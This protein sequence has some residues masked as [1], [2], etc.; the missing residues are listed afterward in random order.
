V[1]GLLDFLALAFLGLLAACVI[2]LVR[3]YRTGSVLVRTQVRWLALAGL[4]V[5]GTLLACWVCAV[6]FHR[7]ELA[8][9]GLVAMAVAIPA[10]TAI[11]ILRTD[12]YDVDRALVSGAA[13]GLLAALVVGVVAAV[14]AVAGLV[15]GQGSTIIAVAATA[16]TLLALN[17]MRRRLEHLLSR[18]L[19][20]ARERALQAV[21]ALERRVSAGQAKPEDLEDVLR[22][23]LRDPGLRLG[24][25]SPGADDLVDGDGRLIEPNDHALAIQIAGQ[26][27]GVLVPGSNSWRPPPREVATAVTMLVEMV[28]LR[29]ELASALVDVEASRT[30]LLRAGYD[31]R[32]RLE[33]D[34]HDGAQQRLVALGMSLRLAQRHLPSGTVDVDGVIDE[35]VAEIGTAVAELRKIAHGL[36]PSNL[37]DG[38]PAALANLTSKSPMPIDLD[39][40]A[41][42]LPDAVCT[43]AYFVAS[44][45][46]TNA[47]KY[48]SA[49]RISLRV[50][51][52]SGSVLVE[53]S[54]DGEGGAALRPGGG[55]AGLVDR[56]H[57]LG[58]A[59][60]VVSPKGGGTMV[61]A[62]LPCES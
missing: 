14:S 12:L 15:A 18:R 37:D 50:A 52:V 51:R 38:L 55:L 32:R 48:A 62:V 11:A 44:E 7:M 46:V 54:D 9:I 35:A 24:Y 27:V 49:N 34:L 13:Y 23:A 39:L 31:E 53:V 59:L 36:R 5:P 8:V 20:P 10:A 30:R 26:Q 21:S 56:V 4:T 6:A 22:V 16:I 41:G 61:E 60:R 25:R 40:D 2:V 43:T 17:P 42:E 29:M 3:R 19:Y 33:R 28:R 45:A 47:V 1:G 57:A 58:G